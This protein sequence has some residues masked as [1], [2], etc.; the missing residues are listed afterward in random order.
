MSNK[1]IDALAF[2]P[3][4]MSESRQSITCEG[5]I[6]ASTVNRF[7]SE[8]E[9]LEHET[10]FCTQR[11]CK[12]CAVFSALELKYSQPAVRRNILRH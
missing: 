1:V 2:C 8:A 5:L 4:Y 11:T 9:K 3:F 7:A 10:S 12:G 6:G